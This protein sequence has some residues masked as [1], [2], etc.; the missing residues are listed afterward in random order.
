MPPKVA[1]LKKLGEGS[2]GCVV[3]RPL[4]CSGK[5]TM[6]TTM[7]E[8]K[9]RQVAKL[10]YEKDKYQNE[11]RLAKLSKSIDPSEEKILV[12][13]YACSVSK[14]TLNDP[15]NVSAISKCENLASINNASSYLYGEKG[16]P[17]PAK[18][19]Q[20]VMPYGGTDIDA[21][22][23]RRKNKISVRSIARMMLPI[24]E[25]LVL[26]RD[27][28]EVHQ[29]IKAENVLAYKTKAILIDF[30]L[31]LPFKKIYA[32]KNYN[33]LK[34]KYRPYPPEYYLASLMIKHSN[35][36]KALRSQEVRDYMMKH[37]KEHL[38]RIQSFFY[39][40][41]TLTE[42]LEES[43]SGSLVVMVM[44]D[45]TRL[46]EYADKIDVY[47][48]GTLLADITPF[49]SNPMSNDAFVS[50]IRSILHPDPRQ[51]MGPEDALAMCRTIA[52]VK[53]NKK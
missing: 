40:Y 37:Y 32:P 14:K 43:N 3:S 17:S 41:Y 38:E 39:P 11:V 6:I 8:G 26:L 9:K 7:D 24:F 27:K 1:K 15:M 33:K 4:E 34:R 31:M 18:V 35:D 42:L 47:S 48:V 36:F 16:S 5:E 10:F 13:T 51:R 52:G 19:W 23:E 12:P 46:E 2:F 25:A 53:K 29:D 28:Q 45:Y 50:F 49:I 20:L 22:L 44:K 30:S 21:A